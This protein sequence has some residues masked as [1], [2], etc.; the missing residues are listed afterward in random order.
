[1]LRIY[2]VMVRILPDGAVQTA[3]LAIEVDALSEALDRRL[4]A[5]LP[6]GP[7]TRR[8]VRAGLPGELHT[9]ASASARSR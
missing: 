8:V 2:P 4:A 9:R 7:I 3:A 5:A 1:M 6:G